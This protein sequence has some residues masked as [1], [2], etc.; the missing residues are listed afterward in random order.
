MGTANL[1]RVFGAGGKLEQ[2]R[3]GAMRRWP[4]QPA[5]FTP[6]VISPLAIIVWGDHIRVQREGSGSCPPANN[7]FYC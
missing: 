3:V 4:A 7:L 5:R 6:L 1:S 2:D